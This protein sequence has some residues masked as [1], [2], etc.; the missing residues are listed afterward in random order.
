MVKTRNLKKQRT[1]QCSRLFNLF[2]VSNYSIIASKSNILLSWICSIFLK[3][4]MEI[5]HES[6]QKE[7]VFIII[8]NSIMINYLTLVSIRSF[9]HCFLHIS[10]NYTFYV[11]CNSYPKQIL[12][13]TNCSWQSKSIC[14]SIDHV[15]MNTSLIRATDFICFPNRII[16]N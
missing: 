8:I 10:K 12:S 5:F 16:F 2:D 9:E 11:L 13:G 15:R 6:I 7:L 14:G 3:F 4:P 1:F